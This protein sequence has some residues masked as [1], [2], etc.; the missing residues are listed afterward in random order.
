[1]GSHA[2]EPDRAD[3]VVFDL[4]PGPDVPFA[5]VKRLPLISGSFWPN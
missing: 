5:E 3:R 1:M 2:E 4:D